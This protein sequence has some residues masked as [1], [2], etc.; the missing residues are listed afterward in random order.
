M[1]RGTNETASSTRAG[2]D[3]PP[4]IALLSLVFAPDGVSTANIMTELSKRLSGL[5]HDISVFT[6][7][8]HYNLDPDAL[9]AQPLSPKWGRVLF[10]SK[11]AGIPVFHARMHPKGRRIL[12]R[13]LDYLSFHAVSTV[14][15]L[16]LG[17]AY[18]IVLAPSPP[19][20]IGLSAI[21][22]A[23]WRRVPFVYNVQEIY[24]DIAVSLGLLRNRIV[25]RALEWVERFIY[26][27]SAAVVV[28]SESFRHRLLDKGVPSGKLHVI[29]NFVDVEFVQPGERH[30]TFS[31]AHLLDERFVVL[32]AG[33]I[34]LTQDF[35][36]VMAAAA[37]LTDLPDIRF[38][39]VGDGA[40]REWLANRSSEL[41]LGN[42]QLVPYQPHG[43]V[44][45]V[46]SSSDVC[47]VP[48]VGGT[49]FDTFPSKIYT[50]M[51][52]GRPAIVSAD[53]D[54]ELT[55]V[56]QDSRCGTVVP[57]GDAV[58]LAEALRGAY[59]DRSALDK[60]GRDGREYVVRH[61]SPDA[62][63]QQYHDLLTAV[64]REKK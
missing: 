63:A 58:A 56:V 23:L 10:Q 30:N 13:L 61:H 43:V 12:T 31:S 44:P 40:R 25:I 39:I 37:M 17:G 4:R 8:P 55:R 52:A 5:G 57:P 15:G 26:R 45:L 54:S 1:T 33:N 9:A 50:I 20:T 46:Y 18:Q 22:L 49:T 53:P 47:I 59:L 14:A 60:M 27:R 2:V 3:R 29:P 21:V 51:S 19:L 32:Y 35:E 6:T 11:H 62:I 7:T 42:V 64:V 16:R 38:V 48:M 41:G 36:T 34:G 24:P 28:I